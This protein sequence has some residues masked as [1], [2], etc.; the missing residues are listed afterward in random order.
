MVFLVILCKGRD[1]VCGINGIVYWSRKC[2]AI[3][4]GPSFLLL[5]LWYSAVISIFNIC[6]KLILALFHSMYL[7]LALLLIWKALPKSQGFFSLRT[8]LWIM[9]SSRFSC[10]T[11]YIFLVQKNVPE[12]GESSLFD[13]FACLPNAAGSVFVKLLIPSSHSLLASKDGN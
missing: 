5:L 13:Q 10:I 3:N 7:L 11:D 1:N 12:D 4:H 8:V 6:H 9:C 2:R